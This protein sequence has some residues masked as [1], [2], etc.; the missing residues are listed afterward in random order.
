MTS[1]T[2]INCSCS[3]RFR[4]LRCG[5]GSWGPAG[6]CAH[7]LLRVISYRSG[8]VLDAATRFSFCRLCGSSVFVVVVVVIV[9]VVV[10]VTVAQKIQQLI[11]I[12]L[13]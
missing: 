1:P 8:T 12:V 3:F 4:R 2:S 7:W 13:V 9:V 11:Y 10:V 6:P 5:A